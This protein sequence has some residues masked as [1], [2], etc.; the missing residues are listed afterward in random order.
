MAEDKLPSP[1]DVLKGLPAPSDILQEGAKKK[2]REPFCSEVK[3]K[4]RFELGITFAIGKWYIRIGGF[5]IG[6]APT[7]KG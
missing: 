3:S 5:Y 4:S 2:Y 6:F 7:S 1:D